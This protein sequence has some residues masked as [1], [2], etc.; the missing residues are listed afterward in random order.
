MPGLAREMM[1]M[2]YRDRQLTFDDLR[3]LRAE[4]YIRDSTLDQKDGF[5]PEIQ[6]HNI[7]RFSESY[8]VVLGDR[9][10]TEFLSGRS[11]RNR[12]QFQQF[13]EDA[14]LD[15]FDVLLV[16][17]T[18]RFG[19]N[20]AECI[21]HKEE[22][23][24]LGKVV[25]FVSQGI[26][27]GSDRDFLNERINE[28][29]DEQYSRN[30]SRYVSAGLAE[31]SEHGYAV[32]PP[33]LGYQSEILAGRKGERKVPN[34]ETMP[35]LIMALGDYATGQH[36]FRDVADRLN[37]QGYR[38]RT[39]RPF[40]GASIR[41]VLGNRFYEGK[42]TYHEGLPDEMVTDGSH[43][44]PQEVKDLWAKCQ[45]IRASRRNTTAGHPRGP[46]RS[47]P[48]SRVL[49][50]H[51]CG[52]PYYGESVRKADQATLRLSHERRGPERDCHSRPRSQSVTALV[53]Q[54]GDRVMP[55]LKLDTTWKTRVTT[56][57]KRQAP[58]TQ[59]QSQQKRLIGAL[60]N[61]RK[62]HLWGDLSDER[63]KLERRSLERQLKLVAIPTQPTELPNLERSAK[64]LEDLPVLWS[65]PGVTH[66]QREELV[67][68]VFH[69]ITIDGKEF[70]SIEPK[71]P[72]AP[73]F[74]SI[75]TSEELGYWE[76]NSPPSPPGTR[77]RRLRL[78]LSLGRL[79]Y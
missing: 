21:R 49:A 70:M 76:P 68:E 23:R 5:G 25:V 69:R 31:K 27:S 77:F 7:E 11:S 19:R 38:T 51:Q 8:G 63:Y 41:D 72:Y 16:D 48:F 74:A 26:I 78:S 56:A 75:V 24:S 45:D 29:M 33:P 39:G 61:L 42:V 34:P 14:R 6:R 18:S 66:E 17:H 32:G 4:G 50:C 30:L 43:E 15:L 40:T 62:Q 65:H 9:W 1:V 57:L 36:S 47:F 58:Q 3:G 2:A 73:L 46:S 64:L 13:L 60:E 53:H 22:L 10:Y 37:A 67:R 12:S 55:Y 35:A 52:S 79:V 44:V 28:T 20:Q 59:D 54:M 71:A